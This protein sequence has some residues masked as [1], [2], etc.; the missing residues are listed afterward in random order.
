MTYP[1]PEGWVG[2]RP[3]WGE[4]PTPAEARAPRRTSDAASLPNWPRKD[5]AAAPPGGD[6]DDSLAHAM[7]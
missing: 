1:L 2:E 7:A 6:D 5:T 4:I 3:E